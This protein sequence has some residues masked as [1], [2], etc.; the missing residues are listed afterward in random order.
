MGTT[1]KRHYDYVTKEPHNPSPHTER[2]PVAIERVPSEMV[3]KGI[4]IAAAAIIGIFI[5]RG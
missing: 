3:K 5:L 2:T 4:I 1:K